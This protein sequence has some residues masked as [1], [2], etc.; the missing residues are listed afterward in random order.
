MKKDDLKILW[1]E[2]SI[3][4]I[5]LIKEAFAQVGLTHRIDV[6]SDGTDALNYLLLRGRY[7]RASRPD[8]IILDLNLPGVS[9]RDIM[10]EIKND[11]NLMNIPLVV[12]T[13]S[14]ADRDVLEGFDISR[15]LYLVKPTTFDDLVK[16][17]GQI[18]DFLL[19][20]SK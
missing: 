6:L 8:L 18:R 4:D 1:V 14:N 3:G 13:S 19:S 11:A 7:Q 15:C 2:D 20:L 12:L 10:K 9:G 5:L 16:I 17:A